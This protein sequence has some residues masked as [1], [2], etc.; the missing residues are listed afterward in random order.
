M[1]SGSIVLDSLCSSDQR[2]RHRDLFSQMV[3]WTATQ[4]DRHKIPTVQRYGANSL[5]I[6]QPCNTNSGIPSI[7]INRCKFDWT[8]CRLFGYCSPCPIGHTRFSSAFSSVDTEYNS[9]IAYCRS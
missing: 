2:P 1:L 7:P 3:L 6:L 4:P 5:P 9:T 8:A